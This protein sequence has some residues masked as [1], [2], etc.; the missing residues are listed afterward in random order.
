[1]PL[2]RLADGRIGHDRP[3]RLV[4]HCRAHGDHG[5]EE[6]PVHV[7]YEGDRTTVDRAAALVLSEYRAVRATVAHADPL[8]ET[9]PADDVLVQVRLPD[10]DRTVDAPE[11]PVQVSLRVARV[12]ECVVA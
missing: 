9:S 10:A 8:V 12:D 11:P 6:H 7:R 5:D 2:Q 1:M 4:N 3:V